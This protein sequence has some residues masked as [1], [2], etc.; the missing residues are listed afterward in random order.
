MHAELERLHALLARKDANPGDSSAEREFYRWGL[1]HF[2][3]HSSPTSC[4]WSTHD[5]RPIPTATLHLFSITPNQAVQRFRDE[6]R[7]Q[8]QRC[9][10]CVHW[11]YTSKDTFREK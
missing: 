11:Y 1:C 5:M 9:D 6:M 2:L 3:E 8:L 10:Q 4:W 7:R